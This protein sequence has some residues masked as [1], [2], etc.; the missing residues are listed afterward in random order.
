MERL[1]DISISQQK[2]SLTWEYQTKASEQGGWAVIFVVAGVELGRLAGVVSFRADEVGSVPLIIRGLGRHFF[3]S[4]LFGW[5]PSEGIYVERIHNKQSSNAI[6]KHQKKERARDANADRP[7]SPVFR[8]TTLT[9][10][11]IRERDISNRL[12]RLLDRDRGILILYKI[13]H[14]DSYLYS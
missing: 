8:Y 10:L 5:A 9:P 2:L 3:I 6:E 11:L 13:S 12:L 1:N 14:L 7:E 4:L